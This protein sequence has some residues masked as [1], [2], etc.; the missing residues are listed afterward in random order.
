MHYLI[1]G[2][3]VIGKLADVN[4]EDS[5][6]EIELLLRLRSWAAQNKKRHVT[7]YFDGGLTG[8]VSKTLSS[9]HMQV[10][11]ASQGQTADDLMIYRIETVKD[12]TAYT[13]VSSDQQIIK[14]AQKRRMKHWPS[15]TL[16]K[17]LGLVLQP[18]EPEKVVTSEKDDPQLSEAEVAEWLDLFG[19]VPERP[20]A[21]PMLP[22]RGVKKKKR[23][24]AS[25]IDVKH[26]RAQLSTD[27]IEEWLAIFGK[28]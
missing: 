8:G 4:L 23:R 10:I 16:V 21:K 1:D 5:H 14:A 6:D 22:L 12:R 17:Q 19:P 24:P 11:F 26:E 20:A 13:L 25:P 27:E 7:L 28:K 3:N 15:E 2:H 9:H 18:S